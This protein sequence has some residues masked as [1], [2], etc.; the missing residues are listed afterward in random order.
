MQERHL[1]I[2]GHYQLDQTT[3]TEFAQM[4]GHFVFVQLEWHGIAAGYDKIGRHNA[5]T[6]KL[7]ELVAEYG[8]LLGCQ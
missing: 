3:P 6:A 4:S 8:S 7:P 1:S 2:V 5:V